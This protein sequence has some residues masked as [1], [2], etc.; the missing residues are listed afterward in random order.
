[1]VI[2]VVVVMMIVIIA[3]MMMMITQVS[4]NI[5]DLFVTVIES[6][7]PE[8]PTPESPEVVLSPD[9]YSTRLDNIL[10][11]MEDVP[12]KDQKPVEE[13][14]PSEEEPTTEKGEEKETEGEDESEQEK[15]E[16]QEEAKEEKETVSEEKKETEDKE[17][18]SEKE[19]SEQDG[20]GG[21][22]SQMK[23]FEIYLDDV[24]VTEKIKKEQEQK[25]EDVATDGKPLSNGDILAA[26]LKKEAAAMK[27]EPEQTVRI[28]SIIYVNSYSA[29]T[30]N[31]CPFPMIGNI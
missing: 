25:K 9:K 12:S 23:E 6:E 21:P 13:E 26:E 31:F 2:V 19:Q 5:Y 22:P 29:Y 10:D 11:E 14:K 1:M 16:D 17:G 15:K 20:P 7:I 18:E 8:E 27:K 28:N 4:S 3:M 30:G 24:D